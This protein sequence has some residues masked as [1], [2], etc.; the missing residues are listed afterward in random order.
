MW[1]QPLVGT[2]VQVALGFLPAAMLDGANR[3]SLV[4]P[5]RWLPARRFPRLFYHPLSEVH[6]LRKRLASREA[7]KEI[8]AELRQG[9]LRIKRNDEGAARE[10]RPCIDS[11]VESD[12]ETRSCRV[13]CQFSPVEQECPSLR[14]ARHARSFEPDRPR[15]DLGFSMNQGVA[16]Q[17]GRCAQWWRSAAQRGTAK[18][19]DF[20]VDEFVDRQALPA[21]RAVHDRRI[22]VFSQQSLEW[23]AA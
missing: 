16:N 23:M 22:H 11:I 6:H 21:A 12:A 9:E 15:H 4:D 20:L 17:V 5:R 7:Y 10:L 18:R 1:R 8:S 19:H 14:P 3:V 13:Q 2:G